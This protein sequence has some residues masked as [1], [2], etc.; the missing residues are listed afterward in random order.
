MHWILLP[1][2]FRE[3]LQ[4]RILGVGH[5]SWEGPTGFSWVTGRISLLE[6]SNT[7]SH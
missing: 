2:Y 4:Q 6:N 7:E 5:L 3:E 1:G